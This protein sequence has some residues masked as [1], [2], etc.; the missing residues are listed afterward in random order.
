MKI[1]SLMYK[2]YIPGL[3]TSATQKSWRGL[4][5]DAITI[6]QVAAKRPNKRI[7]LEAILL[8]L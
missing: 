5:S 2:S 8:C 6:E 1:L 7:I 4:G 3:L